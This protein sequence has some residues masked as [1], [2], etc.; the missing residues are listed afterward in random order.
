[1]CTFHGW[2]CFSHMIYMLG[3]SHGIMVKV[4]DNG[5]VV[6]EFEALDNLLKKSL[7]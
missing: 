7:L 1:M 2:N 4:V 3:M 5:I 6:T